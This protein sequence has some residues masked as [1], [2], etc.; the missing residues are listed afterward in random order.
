MHSPL[1]DAARR[2]LLRS[3][4][5]SLGGEARRGSRMADGGYPGTPWEP[6]EKDGSISFLGDKCGGPSGRAEGWA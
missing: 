4:T 6:I 1:T 3:H 2:D 5:T